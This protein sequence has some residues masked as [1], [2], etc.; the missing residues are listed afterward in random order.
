MTPAENDNPNLY[1]S[2][3]GF[4]VE[5]LGRTGLRYREEGRSYFV[6]AEILAPPGGIM[7]Y[8]SSVLHEVAL[9]TPVQVSEPIRERVLSNIL[10][11]LTSRGI[12]VDL[13]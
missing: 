3:G 6:D 4:S 9:A 8:G 1:R 2:P 11:L 12:R 5:V 7:V 10:A 13:V